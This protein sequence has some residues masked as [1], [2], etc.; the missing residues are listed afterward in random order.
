MILKKKANVQWNNDIQWYYWREINRR[1]RKY[2]WRRRKVLFC[3]NDREIWWY[4]ND[5]IEVMLIN[6]TV[7]IM[8][9]YSL[10]VNIVMKKLV[11]LYDD[12]RIEKE[13]KV[14]WK[15]YSMKSSIIIIQCYY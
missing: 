12:N 8:K 3:V 10:V 7:L 2:W 4:S 13:R 14:I 6:L 15:K 9:Y 11:M 1:W 5:N